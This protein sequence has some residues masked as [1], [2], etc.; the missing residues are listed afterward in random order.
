MG[1]RHLTI[2]KV[3]GKVKI[4][5]YGQWDGYP[6]GQGAVIADFLQN[7]MDLELF[8]KQV[9]SLKKITKKALETTWIDCGAEE[10]SPTV[11][12]AVAKVHSESFP[13]FSR[14]TGAKILNLIHNGTLESQGHDFKSKQ[15]LKKVISGYK[16]THVDLDLDFLKSPGCEY[17]Y[18]IDL[19]EKTVSVYVG[20]ELF[21][22]Y[23]FKA[24]TPEF[25]PKLENIIEESWE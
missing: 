12:M 22:S 24:F 10:G 13:Q 2:V 6:M 25:M 8:K 4:A 20:G 7:K 3:N 19:D 23:T 21:G 14:D 5:Q 16:V 11:S 17:A 9:R 18:E 15:L 1:T